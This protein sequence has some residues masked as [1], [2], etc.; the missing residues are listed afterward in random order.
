MKL[1]QK[2]SA[3]VDPGTSYCDN[4]GISLEEYPPVESGEYS[5]VEPSG[6]TLKRKRVLTLIIAFVVFDILVAVA[7]LLFT[8]Q[9]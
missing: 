3:D 4:C 5:R 2:C 1:C 8:M 6:A 7:V 9:A